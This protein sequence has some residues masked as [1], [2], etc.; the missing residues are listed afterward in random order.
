MRKCTK[1]SNC[2]WTDLTVLSEEEE[3][4]YGIH[5]AQR[6]IHTFYTLSTLSKLYYFIALNDNK[7]TIKIYLI[8]NLILHRFNI[9]LNKKFVTAKNA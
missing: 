3:N 8:R 2:K 9:I 1:G 5:S 4:E 6:L 7:I